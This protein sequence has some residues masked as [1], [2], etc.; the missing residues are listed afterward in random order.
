MLFPLPLPG[1]DLGTWLTM[2]MMRSM[3]LREF[4]LPDIRLLA[5]KLVRDA[6]AKDPL[7]QA[8]ALRDWIEDH[9]QF[10]RDPEGQELLHGPLWMVRRVLTEGSVQVDCDDIAMLAAALGKA[11]GLRARFVVVG[12]SS[13]RAPFRHIWTELHAP[14]NT[15]PWVQF[16]ITREQQELPAVISRIS[17]MG[18]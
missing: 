6:D 10:V 13:P 2:T 11:V 16:D 4:M 15:G 17:R 7:E 12:F 3:V 9:T 5:V 18:V 14:S 8:N 1:G